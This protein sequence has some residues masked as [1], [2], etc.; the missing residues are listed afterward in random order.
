MGSVLVGQSGGPTSVINASLVGVI[1]E[2]FKHENI[3]KVY[4][5]FYGIEGILEENFYEFNKSMDLDQL[6]TTPA[7]ALGSVRFKLPNNLDDEIYIKIVNV[8][9]KYNIKYF[10]YI[11]GNDSMDTCNKISKYCKINN[12]DIKAIGIPKTIDNDLVETDHCPGYGSACKFVATSLLEI[13]RDTNSYK[14]GRVTI[15]EI[16]GRDAGWLTASAA[17]PEVTGDKV[18]LIYLPEVAFDINEFLASVKEIY[19]RKNKVLIAVSEGIRDKDGEYILKYRNFNNNDNFGHLQLGGVAEVLS[20]IVGTK[21]GYPVRAI[22]FS[23]LQRCASHIA[24]LADVNE[25]IGCGEHAILEALKGNTNVMITMIR[26]NGSITYS[27]ASLDDVANKVKP[28]PKEWIIN[29]N[30]I[31]NE[32]IKYALPL[33]Q[34]ESC[35]KFIN[36]LPSYSKIKA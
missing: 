9:K 30:Q 4:G 14:R 12:L 32:Y 3:E 10:F 36:G 29:N 27:T 22:E 25:A 35:P 19:S 15:V 6:S 23:L 21:L 24:S 7:A 1:K 18:D 5:S 11:G 28:F 8:F 20:E 34:G 33:I 2:A 17:L 31:S 13:Y 16:M 26:K